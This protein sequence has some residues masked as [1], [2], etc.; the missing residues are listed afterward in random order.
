[1][2]TILNGANIA[3]ALHELGHNFGINHASLTATAVTNVRAEY[4]NAL[5][6]MGT[7]Y[8]IESS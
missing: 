6:I 5:D 1:M 7:A 2:R 4:G 8:E 3:T